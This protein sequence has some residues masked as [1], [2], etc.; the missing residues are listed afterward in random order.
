MCPLALPL[1]TLRVVCVWTVSVCAVC[2][3]YTNRGNEGCGEG[4][5]N[6]WKRIGLTLGRMGDE[7]L[8]VGLNEAFRSKCGS[9]G[10][11]C[12]WGEG[13]Q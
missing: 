12:Y 11:G 9:G 1:R 6:G 10:E 7:S 8:K 2:V 3:G 5:R 13:A 4:R